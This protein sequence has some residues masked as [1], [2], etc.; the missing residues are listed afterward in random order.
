MKVVKKLRG[1]E[2][3]DCRE[4]DRLKLALSSFSILVLEKVVSSK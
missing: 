1:K 2:N 4:L 3:G